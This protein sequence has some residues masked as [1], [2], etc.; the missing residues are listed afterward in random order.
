MQKYQALNQGHTKMVL[1]TFFSSCRVVGSV[2]GQ[3]M[4]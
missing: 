4:L 1:Q 2:W 3:H